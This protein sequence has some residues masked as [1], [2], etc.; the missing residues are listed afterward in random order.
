MSSYVGHVGGVLDELSKAS[1]AS[2]KNIKSACSRG[3]SRR[4]QKKKYLALGRM[5]SSKVKS[6]ERGQ[7]GTGES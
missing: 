2:F 4:V 3:H 5:G 7:G 1:G 6:K